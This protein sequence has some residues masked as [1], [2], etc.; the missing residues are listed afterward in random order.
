MKIWARISK[1]MSR[2]PLGYRLLIYIFAFSSIFTLLGTGAQLYWEYRTDVGGI[3]DVLQ[4]IEDS[5]LESLTTSRWMLDDQQT[6]AQMNGILRLP[7][8]HYVEILSQEDAPP[9]G[10]GGP[11]PARSI[12]RTYPMAHLHRDQMIGVGELRVV[13]TLDGVYQRLRD[14]FLII[15]GT[16]AVQTFATSLFILFIVQY[17]FTRHLHVLGEHAKRL[18]LNQ[19][20][21]LLDL[22]RSKN[23]RPDELDHVVTAMEEMRIRLIDDLAALKAVEEDRER[24]IVDLEAKNAEMERFSYTVSHDFKSPLITIQGFL[25]LLKKDIA[26]GDTERAEK[27]MAT[28]YSAVE[29]MYGL[30]QNLL[31][32]S[33]AGRL[34]GQ[35]EDV[36]MYEV[37]GEAVELVFGQI[38]ARGVKVRISSQLPV[39]SGDGSR[40]R[41]V[42]QNLIENSIKF[43][44]D[45]ADPRIEIGVEDDG[46]EAVFFVRDNGVGIEPEN[47]DGLFG[48]F[49]KLDEKAEG[50]G[51]GLAL[52]QRIVI[53]HRGRIWVESEGVGKGTTFRFTLPGPD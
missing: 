20:G 1:H 41:Q 48:L 8:V 36:S 28:I 4:Q 22:K 15:L 50:S 26:A 53:V 2:H 52:V 44:G 27:D 25:G 12:T 18:S 51:I 5:Y 3:H 42:L 23:R 37:A 13:A 6:L 11:I 43:M 16:Q 45:Q 7:D 33:R 35:P 17:L 19:L 32:L 30:L 29:K 21:I 38:E 31:E 34:I 39:V 14:Q 9:L 40:L 10:V 24:L 46:D 47:H 49:N